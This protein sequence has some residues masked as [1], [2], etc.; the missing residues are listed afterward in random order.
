MKVIMTEDALENYG[1]E[2]RDVV[3][4][5]THV[6]TKWMPAKQFYA[7]NRPNGYH[8]GYDESAKGRPLYDLKRVDTGED[9]GSSLYWWEIKRI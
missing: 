7:L 1:E 4:E 8:P 3:F 6:S 5:V 9:F 2:Y